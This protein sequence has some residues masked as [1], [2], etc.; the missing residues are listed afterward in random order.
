MSRD[1]LIAYKTWTHVKTGSTYTV[2]GIGRCGTN[3]REG[4]ESV[5][6]VSHAYGRLCYRDVDEFLDGRFVPGVREEKT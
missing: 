3:S 1:L 6:Y 5:I 4:E 2:L